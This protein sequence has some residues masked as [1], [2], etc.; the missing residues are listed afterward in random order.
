MKPDRFESFLKELERR[1]STLTTITEIYSTLNNHFTSLEQTLSQKSETLES[2]KEA[3]KADIKKC[4]ESLENRENSIPE[5][6][7]V[8][9]ARIEEQRAYGIES[10]GSES[11]KGG[12]SEVLRMYFRRM[13]S[14]G[15]IKYLI[16]KRK[17][18]AALRTE[19]AEA[20]GEAVDPFRLVLDAVED[21]VEMKVEGKVGIAD[22]RWACGMLIQAAVPVA[23]SVDAGRS[24]KERAA[25][26]L[27]KWKGVLGD[28]EGVGAGEATMFLQM[29]IG[30][31]LKHK[32]D[33]E[34]FRK[35][36]LEFA[37]RRDMPKFALAL[38]F[39]DKM[40]D[41]IDDLVKSGKELEAVYFASEVGLTERFPPVS[42]LKSCLRNC[43]KNANT[44]S[45]NG[46]STAALEETNNSEL[47]ASRSIIK[48]VEDHKLESQFPIDGLKKRVTQ[49]EKAKV[50]RKK[51]TASVSKPSNK[52]PHGGPSSS[53]R[54]SNKAGR[55]ADNTSPAFR[56][57]PLAT[58][59]SAATPYRYDSPTAS[60]SGSALYGLVGASG[61][62]AAGSYR[63]QT[64][65]G[66][67]FDYGAAVP[68]YPL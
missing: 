65:Y 28:V 23:A 7:S 40:E 41:I 12:L 17:E 20:V 1:K 31:A 59:Y 43:R 16:T 18:L 22:T 61:V 6:E 25:R 13:E 4:L 2:Q 37:S 14:S 19:M 27:D 15:L 68:S 34:F 46:N 33:D 39:R 11:S 5:R 32:F 50:D 54:P 60:G 9:A 45:K 49:L 48:C 57:Q 36:I 55:F 38:G 64:S 26:V 53:F 24:L 10:W 63:G 29:V 52:R 30:F 67:A 42:L 62:R 56:H 3:L 21:F 44:I 58:R 66:G 8:A 35:L 47:I 51:G